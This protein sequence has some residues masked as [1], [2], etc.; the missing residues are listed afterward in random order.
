MPTRMARPSSQMVVLA[1]TLFS[2]DFAAAQ[3]GRY[4]STSLLRVL[5]TS[6][7]GSG[8]Y[9][10]LMQ[11]LYLHRPEETLTFEDCLPRTGT[12]SRCPV[13]LMTLELSNEPPPDATEANLNFTMM[14]WGDVFI[15]S[16]T[17]EGFFGMPEKCNY[18][19]N[20]TIHAEFNA[21]SLEVVFTI[22][23]TTSDLEECTMSSA[24]QQ[25]SHALSIAL[26]MRLPALT[27]RVVLSGAR[28]AVRGGVLLP[29]L[30]WEAVLRHVSDPGTLPSDALA[31]R[32]PE[33]VAVPAV[34]PFTA[35][36]Q[37]DL[38]LQFPYKHQVQ[39]AVPA[40]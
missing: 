27:A 25:V 38:T 9:E 35:P 23:A 7:E 34:D 5:S 15:S 20:H 31:T 29:R 37:L 24:D 30:E 26:A 11:P 32:C 17:A 3:A 39:P 18:V 10:G 22:L 28:A 8:Y 2:L 19:R 4:N 12:P 21:S 16:P 1:I 13:E 6:W 36:Y 14:I 40:T 33:N